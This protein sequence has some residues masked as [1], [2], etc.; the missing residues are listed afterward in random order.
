MEN[1]QERRIK[2]ALKQNRSR[3]MREVD[4]AGKEKY[5]KEFEDRKPGM[6]EL[7]LSGCVPPELRNKMR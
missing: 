5:A 6:E 1:K 3:G 7:M 4:A 2:E